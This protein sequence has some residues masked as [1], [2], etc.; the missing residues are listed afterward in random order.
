MST[1]NIIKLIRAGNVEVLSVCRW[2]PGKGHEGAVVGACK[3]ASPNVDPGFR[4]VQNNTLQ[5]NNATLRRLRP[6]DRL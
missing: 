5:S 4:M 1:E 2:P 6:S 3:L